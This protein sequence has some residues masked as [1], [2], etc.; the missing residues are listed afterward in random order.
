VS[1]S[2]RLAIYLAVVHAT[3]AALAVWALRAQPLW[4]ALA[5]VSLAV[6]LAVGVALARSLVRSVALPRETAHWLADGDFATRFRRVGQPE[7]DAQLDLYNTMIDRL[8]AARVEAEEQQQ[9]LV[10]MIQA[11]PAGVIVLDFD[12]RVTSINPVAERMLALHG[13]ERA[14]LTLDAVGGALARQLD[15]LPPNEQRLIS[16]GDGR[17][18]RVTHGTFVDRG[19][20]RSFFTIE[21]LTDEI[22]RLERAAHEKLIR[23]LSHE[24]NNTVGAASS[25]LQSCLTYGVQ[26]KAEDRADFERALSVVIGRTARLNDFMRGFADV[27][28]LPAPRRHSCDLREVVASIGAL[29]RAQ[30]EARRIAWRVNV[31]GEPVTADVDRG[32]VEQAILNVVKNAIEAV[33]H[34]GEVVVRVEHVGGR[35]RLEVQDSGPG[36]SDAA[37]A[38]VFTPFYSTKAEGQGLGL[39]L[40][41]EVMNAHGFP[42]SL[43]SPPGG[44]TVFTVWCAPRDADR[45]VGAAVGKPSN[46]AT[47]A[48]H[49]ATE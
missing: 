29:V 23:L 20:S 3:A 25:L 5:E 24:V 41:Q 11:S 13:R 44:P 2:V 31:P 47:E 33:D 28:R 37:R 21:E 32:Q 36:L 9:F 22:R 14:G 27:Y 4:L 38:N 45:V 8:R 34:D 12:R 7:V 49:G 15:A 18:L 16:P 39:T 40:V 30:C 43:E 19:F 17:R 10:Q 42:F 26:L 35:P 46:N 48:R 1:L 6:S